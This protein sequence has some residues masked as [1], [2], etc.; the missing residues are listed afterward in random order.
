MVGDPQRFPYPSSHT[1]KTGGL[2]RPPDFYATHTVQRFNVKIEREPSCM[3][4]YSSAKERGGV[5]CYGLTRS[6]I[7]L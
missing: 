6:K 3:L 2:Q 7:L 1:F 5:G 4:L